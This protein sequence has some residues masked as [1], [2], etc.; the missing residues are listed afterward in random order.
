[1]SHGGALWPCLMRGEEDSQ[2]QSGSGWENRGGTCPRAPQMGKDLTA[3][4]R[5]APGAAVP[6]QAAQSTQH[7]LEP[8]PWS[9]ALT[10]PGRLLCHQVSSGFGTSNSCLSAILRC[11]QPCR[12]SQKARK[13]GRTIPGMQSWGIST[14]DAGLA[15]TPVGLQAPEISMWNPPQSLNFPVFDPP[16][17]MNSS[18]PAHTTP[19]IGAEPP[20]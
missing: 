12:N 6:H 7:P 18:P 20:W 11:F 10:V 19:R 15:R 16:R 9:S 3:K 1:M 5:A 4:L 17:A 8:C 13:A 2:H 14:G